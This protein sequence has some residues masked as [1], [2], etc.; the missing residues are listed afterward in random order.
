MWCQAYKDFEGKTFQLA[1]PAEYSYKEIIEFVSD[2]TAVKKPLIDL[3]PSL[4]VT[5]LYSLDQGVFFLKY[6]SYPSIIYTILLL[7][8]R[9]M[10]NILFTY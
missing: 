10:L 2:V 3:P 6:D 1:G 9:I 7:N 5:V 8:F 4:A